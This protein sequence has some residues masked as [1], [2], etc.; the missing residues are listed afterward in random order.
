[1]RSGPRGRASSSSRLDVGDTG[2]LAGPV[3]V[4]VR[5]GLPDGPGPAP[6]P[7]ARHLLRLAAARHHRVG[8]GHAAAVAGRALPGSV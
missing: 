8:R 4:A 3:S 6:T 5:P 7:A 1:M 2:Q